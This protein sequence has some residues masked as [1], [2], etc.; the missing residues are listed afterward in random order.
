VALEQ[1]VSH[2]QGMDLHPVAVTLARVTYLLAITPERLLRRR[3]LT[4]PVFLGDSMRWQQADTVMTDDGLTVSTA[5]PLQLVDDSLHFPEGVVRHPH[6][7]DR[8]VADLARRA[9]ERTPGTRPPGIAGLLRRHRVTGDGD[10]AAVVTTFKK[11]CRLHDA[12]RDHL[13]SYYIRNM[14]R[15]LSFIRADG[16]VDVLLGNPP[17]LA[18]RS[19]PRELQRSY[20]HLAQ[21]LGLWAGGKVAT[22][23]DLSDLFVARA[24]AQYLRPRG[25]F[26]FVMP[27]AV[28]SR[29]QFAGFRSGSWGSDL[30]VRFEATEEFSRVKPPLFPVPACVVSGHKH[31]LAASMPRRAVAWSGRLPADYLDWPSAAAHLTAAG[32]EVSLAHDS[33]ASPYRAHFRQGAT[34]VPRMLVLVEPVPEGPLGVASGFRQVTS[35]RSPNEKQPWKSLPGLTGVIEEEFAMP[36]H[37]GETIVAYRARPARLAV[38]PMLAGKLLDGAQEQLDEFPGI[39]AWWREA[40]RIWEAEKSP[41]SRL[42]LCDR[43]DFHAGLTKQSP[44]A[45]H[46]VVYA[47]SGQ[48][49]AACRVEEADAIIDHTLY[50]AAV[51]SAAEGRYLCAVLNSQ[52]LADAVKGL[53]SRGQHNPRHFDMHIFSLPFPMFD[54]KNPGHN[55]VAALA[56]RA[57][58][59]A[60]AVELDDKWQFQKAR[61]VVREALQQD[62]VAHEIDRAVADLLEAKRSQC[63]ITRAPDLMDALPGNQSQSKKR[64]ALGREPSHGRTLEHGGH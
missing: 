26:A 35:A 5:D 24:V 29:R 45:E 61:R 16:Q 42:S 15:P 3:E 33:A 34:L 14:A 62:G 31:R 18:Y 9:A 11:L 51:D 63:G 44:G 46:R 10:R 1:V 48:H 27:F 40:E 20:R 19:M 28:L 22:Q 21:S 59:V 25:T 37:L 52:T 2:V 7:F 17:W 43:V 23:Q 13:W 53:Q 58:R 12:G 8:L 56:E 49:L 38:V 6:R 30:N 39:A 36:V 57:E 54:R 41:S 55:H 32:D 60:A 47:K 50:W 4:V 64:R